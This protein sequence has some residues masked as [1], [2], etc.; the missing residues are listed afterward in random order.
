M[1]NYFGPNSAAWT[2]RSGVVL[3]REKN[4]PMAFNGAPNI[5]MIMSQTGKMGFDDKQSVPHNNGQNL[6]SQRDGQ[7]VGLASS[8]ENISSHP[9]GPHY[10]NASIAHNSNMQTMAASNS[11][12]HQNMIPNSMTSQSGGF[13]VMNLMDTG[14]SD[15]NF[16]SMG[17]QGMT[18]MNNMMGGQGMNSMG[19]TMTSTMNPA[20]MGGQGMTSMNNIMG[21]QGMNPMARTMT[22][23]MSSS[24][25]GGQGM[26]SMN[27]MM[28]GQGM[29]S[30][31]NM[32]GGQG[33]NPMERTLTSTTNPVSM[34]GQGM[35]TMSNLMGGQGMPSVNSMGRTMT[36]TMNS[37]GYNMTG[38]Q[39]NVPLMNA[40]IPPHMFMQAVNFDSSQNQEEMN[41]T[42]ETSMDILEQQQ[43]MEQSKLL[44][45]FKELRQ[46]QI[47]QQEML[48][49]QQQD[50]LESLRYE[51]Q[52]VH[53]VIAKQRKNQWGG[54]VNTDLGE[55]RTPPKRQKAQGSGLAK[56]MSMTQQ[57]HQSQQAN[58]S[59]K[60]YVDYANQSALP[61]PVMYVPLNEDNDEIKTNPDLFSDTN[62]HVGSQCTEDGF[63]QLP[64]SASEVGEIPQLPSRKPVSR[65][66]T[67]H[68]SMKKSLTEDLEHDEGFGTQSFRS[69][70]QTD[71]LRPQRQMDMMDGQEVYHEDEDSVQL[72]EQNL[73]QEEEYDDDDDEEEEE[74]FDFNKEEDQDHVTS[75]EEDQPMTGATLDDRPVIGLGEKKTFE[76]LL[77]E[78]L[79]AEE[80]R[81][82][83]QA[84]KGENI[85][86]PKRCFLKKGQGIARYGLQSKSK[87][88]K[89]LK[90]VKP[91]VDSNSSQQNR[92]SKP[93]TQQNKSAKPDSN[94]SQQNKTARGDNR[95]NK[96][97][98]GDNLTKHQKAGGKEAVQETKKRGTWQ[99]RNKL[100]LK[101]SPA[102]NQKLTKS[103]R[104][105]TLPKYQQTNNG[106]DQKVQDKRLLNKPPKGELPK[107]RQQIQKPNGNA[108]KQQRTEE[109]E[110][111]SDSP[112]FMSDND[113]FV[114]RIKQ[115]A[116]NDVLEKEEVDEFEYLENCADNMSFCS[117]SSFVTKILQKDRMKPDPLKPLLQ[118]PRTS[119]AMQLQATIKNATQQH[120]NLQQNVHRNF[121][122]IE[123]ENIKQPMLQPEQMKKQ[124]LKVTKPQVQSDEEES[125]EEDEE[126]DENEDEEE[127][128]SEEESSDETESE[129]DS[130]SDDSDEE[131][132]KSPSKVM[133]RKVASQNTVSNLL[134]K[135]KINSHNDSSASLNTSSFIPN[136]KSPL[137]ISKE[138]TA[139]TKSK[140]QGFNGLDESVDSTDFKIHSQISSL[141]KST[142]STS[143]DG[144]ND[145]D[146]S[147]NSYSNLKILPKRTGKYDSSETDSKFTSDSD[148]KHQSES[149]DK[150]SSDFDD[151]EEW[152]DTTLKAKSPKEKRNEQEET[153]NGSETPPTSKLVSKLFPK[154]K[155]QPSKQQ[156]QD[157]QKL[158][159]VNHTAANDGVQSKVLREKLAELEKEI[160]KFRSE[161]INLDKL[162]K[163]REEGLSRLKK[164]ITDFEKEKNKELIRIQDYKTEEMKK[165][166]HEKKMF[167]KYQKAARDIPN[168]KEREE[169]EMLKNQMTD[170]QEEMKRK[171]TRWTS[172]NS[173]LRSKIEQLEQENTE[174]KEEIKLMEKR[175]LEWLQKEQNNKGKSKSAQRSSTPSQLAPT[176]NSADFQTTD[177]DEEKDP[178][179]DSS[180]SKTSYS[181]MSLRA[182]QSATQVRVPSI[183]PQ[184]SSSQPS[185]QNRTAQP[186]FTS[187][188][189]GS[190]AAQPS[191]TGHPG[192][193]RTS[194]QP[195]PAKSPQPGFSNA[196]Q[197]SQ[198]DHLLRMSLMED[199]PRGGAVVA[200]PQDTSLYTD[201]EGDTTNS[202]NVPRKT[203]SK[204]SVD[205]SMI[206]KGNSGYDEFQH[207][208]GKIERIY[209]TGAREILFGNGTRKEISADGKSIVVSFFNGDIKQIMP[210]QRVVYYYAE[211]QT[212]HSHYPDGLEVLQFPNNQQEKHYPDGTKEITFADQTI[213]YLFPNGS[214]ESIFSDGTVIRVDKNGDKTMEFPNGQREIHTN[215]YKKREYP[216][217]TVK[218]VYPDGRQET[219]YSNGRIRVKDRDGNVIV[220]RRC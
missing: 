204:Y 215:D 68:M 136:P 4:G 160:E 62:S 131:L 31:N 12:N 40:N 171:E 153:S 3:D 102:K 148:N 94:S 7:N 217:G 34:G 43:A 109:R 6:Q 162:R 137:V 99:D 216:D 122:N 198:Q 93:D 168:K 159:T 147:E 163:E 189:G 14:A 197:K 167:E 101:T 156:I 220:D 11:G 37:T 15:M 142:D 87:P 139:A 85:E 219:R 65:V 154:L 127:E 118:S 106:N 83:L 187:L 39:Q 113:S 96:M 48:M 126:D 61:C 2:A 23:T 49:K 108:N 32:M 70:G 117:Q 8:S 1:A 33:M 16:V 58:Q 82:R 103:P 36:S 52:N 164:E 100:N 201:T 173:R 143:D 18:S 76:E 28:G 194:S 45:R 203:A 90:S 114:V 71:H 129:D 17:G 116:K 133:T 64:D 63:R 150:H 130:D 86:S 41:K 53:S 172:S 44:H 26:T 128:E 105:D 57:S 152:G 208:D 50:Q 9:N 55:T 88:T 202:A 29:T 212:T 144:K 72:E 67:M 13:S 77:E 196:Q 27:N 10:S 149:D 158:Q 115:R 74:D 170:L 200:M 121:V 141:R 78:Q 24:S 135:L 174:L 95:P 178:V 54:Q 207:N 192:P 181:Q 123:T 140:S 79:R 157:Q 185:L 42:M 80:E 21:G 120:E 66:S 81:M 155:P 145:S 180:S 169:I 119:V 176:Q 56:A 89:D 60:S 30:M 188:P 186:N 107:G 191:F 47:Q 193:S 206:D 98:K 75:E 104:E 213:K 161:N 35:T 177:S 59:Q 175:R 25:M 92:L 91:K 69:S 20:S 19:R 182:T 97:S 184:Q 124:E 211:A 165:L 151:E 138:V 199:V 179:R 195:G 46:L 84:S 51:Q 22:S 110:T 134:Q 205:R 5:N 166:K 38:L 190:K 218:T 125:S 73:D 132:P 146:D 112:D 111:V 209:K 214:E 210:D 183:P